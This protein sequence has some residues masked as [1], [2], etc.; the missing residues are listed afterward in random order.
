MSTVKNIA[1][2][3]ADEGSQ[4]TFR[5]IGVIKGSAS[6]LSQLIKLARHHHAAQQ[7][8]IESG[9]A[10]V[11]HL[12]KITSKM[13]PRLADLSQAFIEISATEKQIFT[14]YETHNNIFLDGLAKPVAQ[15]LQKERGHLQ[16][17]EKNYHKRHG[18]ILVNIKK[19]EKATK[20]CGK[21]SAEQLQA[22]I[23]DLTNTM[24]EMKEHRKE[25]LKEILLFERSRY[26]DIVQLLND[27]VQSQ[28]DTS[29]SVIQSLSSQQQHW[30][31]IAGTSN[32]LSSDSEALLT[33][34]GVK[35]RTSHALPGTTG[36][37]EGYYDEGYYEE[38]YD[39]YYEEGY[40]EYYEEGYE[41]GYNE[42]QGYSGGSSYST[43]GSSYSGGSS[44]T[45]AAAAPTSAP[46][47]GGY[48]AP[49]PPVPAAKGFKARA[50]YDYTGTHDYELSFCAGDII[51]VTQEDA[52]TGWWTGDLNGV[53][54]PFPGNYVERI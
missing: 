44:Y 46:S 50:L 47:A 25:A 1:K 35:E 8:A 18:E 2:P 19:A 41:E 9:K 3:I 49:P 13:E 52:S 16:S 12:V 23:Q 51:T 24:N 53:V 29:Q 6:D 54:G 17:F 22:A 43:G 42:T 4:E 45:A 40:D 31:D 7:A 32:N 26:C 39:E 14:T 37:D 10:L 15:S 21:K 36:G 27:I 33:R 11:D 5:T 34:T 48:R 20:K 28:I 38:G 30:K